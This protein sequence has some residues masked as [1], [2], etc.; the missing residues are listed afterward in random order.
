MKKVS[1]YRVDL[2]V[3]RKMMGWSQ[4][5][6]AEFF[7]VRRHNFLFW[8]RQNYIPRAAWER[9]EPLFLLAAQVRQQA[10]DEPIT[11]LQSG[12]EPHV[13]AELDLRIVC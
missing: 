10:Q 11:V 4:Y 1:Y 13:V 5:T 8:E 9:I 7:G 3:V 2:A 12:E 6:A